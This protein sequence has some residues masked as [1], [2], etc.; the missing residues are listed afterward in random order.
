MSTQANTP[1]GDAGMSGQDDIMGEKA[2]ALRLDSLT[3]GMESLT[4][5]PK[6]R[7][8]VQLIMI[9]GLIVVAG[10]SLVAMRKLGMGPSGASGSEVKIDYDEKGSLASVNHQKVL[11]DLTASHIDQQVP[12]EQ[13]QRNPFKMAESLLGTLKIKQPE[14][15]DDGIIKTLKEKEEAERRQREIEEHRA[16]VQA[17][18]DSLKVHSVLGGSMPIARINNETVR[19]GQ[20]VAD[21]FIVTAI[22]GRSVDITLDGQTYTISMD[23]DE[24]GGPKPAPASAPPLSPAKPVTGKPNS[25][26]PTPPTGKK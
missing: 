23:G 16:L 26:P 15:P 12:T 18:R 4:E 25:T 10:G 17:T 24:E 19:V 1:K 13:V 14:P 2:P 8:P 7:L 5:A 11:D 9:V 3:G 6:K 22:H 21:M 20:K